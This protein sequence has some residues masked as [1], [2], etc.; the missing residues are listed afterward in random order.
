MLNDLFKNYLSNIFYR[1]QYKNIIALSIINIVF[2]TF[3]LVPID[4]V[5]YRIDK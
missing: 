1:I 4:P 5:K 3:L 2:F